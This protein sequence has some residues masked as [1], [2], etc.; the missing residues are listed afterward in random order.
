MSPESSLLKVGADGYIAQ[1]WT[2]T[3]RTPNFY[4]GRRKERTFETAF[5][6]YGAMQNLVRASG[7]RVW[8]LNDPVE[9]DPNHKWD[10]YRMNWENTLTASLFQPEVWRYEIMPWPERVFNGRYP[11]KDSSD[12]RPLNQLERTPN[13]AGLGGFGPRNATE[14][15]SMPKAYETELQAVVRAL[16]EMQQ[17]EEAI[18]WE[19]SGTPG[20]GVLVSD[21]MMFQR[22]HPYPSDPNLG[23]FY[24]LA[25]PLLKR[26]IP[27]EPVQIESATSTGFLE[28]Y[29]LLLL[30]YEGQKPPLATFHDALGRWVRAGGALVVLDDDHDPYCAVREWWN[31]PP[32]SYAT[33][34]QHL[35]ESLELPKDATGL[36]RVGKGV[37]LREALS[38]AALTYASDGAEVVRKLARQAAE[39]V[40]LSWRETNALALRRGPYLIA[41]GLDESIP[42]AASFVLHGR[43]IDLFDAQLPVR[44]EIT[45]SPG[46]RALLFDLD[47]INPTRA[48][49]VAAA[50][51]VSH[52]RFEN[53]A[54]EFNAEGVADT[55][56]VVR[57][58]AQGTPSRVLVAGKVLPPDDCVASAG[59]LQLRF[60][61]SVKGVTVAVHFAP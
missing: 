55:E 52:I 46:K 9:D 26:G 20:V 38:P 43:F 3:A 10:D 61:N 39:A 40:G 53:D 42:N 57:I 54:L 24:G 22:A 56:A 17:P 8:Y 21:T 18:R 59:T 19:H 1:I 16:G 41:A 36:H 5:L 47:A 11:A 48:Q 50:C 45:L 12:T 60:Q 27:V 35:F 13:G 32:L 29:R 2:G 23:S 6:E 14:R 4:E 34:R 33:P 58:L 49:V 15:V 25:M 7:R 37:V 31:T 30:T 51:P 28:R 44:N